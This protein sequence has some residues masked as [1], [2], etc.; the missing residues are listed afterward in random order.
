MC[1]SGKNSIFKYRNHEKNLV[2]LEFHFKYK[3]CL[4]NL[5]AEYVSL[6]FV[7]NLI[8]VYLLHYLFIY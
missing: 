1:M 5:I 8:F 7:S 3:Q 4:L 2:F 6:K